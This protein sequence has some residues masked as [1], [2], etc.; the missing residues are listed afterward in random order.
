MVAAAA[1]ARYEGRVA[2][3][4]TPLPVTA[5]TLGQIQFEP[6]RV[7]AAEALARGEPVVLLV[8]KQE[9]GT[10]VETILFAGSGRAAQSTGTW[11]FSGLWSGGQ[12]LTLNGH[13]LD[14]D[15]SCFCRACET[16]IGFGRDED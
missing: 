7:Q 1:G 8:G 14:P 13:A 10:R 12:L 16:A 15:G 5:E 3:D 4:T 9:E 6:L 11:V 2:A